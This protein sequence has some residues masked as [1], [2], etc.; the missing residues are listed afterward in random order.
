MRV[1]A[2]AW[3]K[4]GLCIAVLSLLCSISR[5]ADAPSNVAGT[6]TFSVSGKAGNAKQTIVIQQDGTKITGTFKGPRQSGTIEGT[7]DDN[8]ISFHVKARRD[9]D[10]TGTVDGDTM[11]GTL[12]SGNKSGDF[13]ASRR[14]ASSS[15]SA[16]TE[17]T[18]SCNRVTKGKL[19]RVSDSATNGRATRIPPPNTPSGAKAKGM[20]W[21]PGGEFS[22]GSD[23]PQFPDARPWH[24][25]HVNGFYVDRTE[26]SNAQYSAFVR[27]TGYVT[28]AE[29][30]PNA[31]DYP[32]ASPEKLVAGSV[33]FAP[34][35]HAV[36]LNNPYQWWNFVKGANWR[37]PEGPQSGL[38]GRMNH[39][40]VQVAYDDAVAYCSWIGG[41]LPTEAEFEFAA[42]G[43]S[44]R[45]HYVWGDEF[46]P[47]GKFMA[48]TFQGEFPQTNTAEDG[49]IGAA[50]VGS[51]PANGYGL[52]DLAG[53]VWEWTSDW[54][55]PDYYQTLAAAGKVAQN[56]RGPSASFDPGEPGVPK[57]VQRGGSFLCTEQYCSRYMVGA[58]GRGAPDTG[59][60]HVGFRCVSN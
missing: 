41:R 23:E 55:R 58:R 20:V 34:Q 36:L 33:V 48:N 56:P 17:T 57:R 26:V 38:R 54:Y 8:K 11:K 22:M 12:T 28:V 29:Q 18:A 16:Q 31:K 19:L 6:W 53:N 2:S 39:P 5:G 24:Q 35:A 52:F 44:A 10:Y 27:A 49:Y 25:V 40:V 9:L 30:I 42:G 15:K 50:P 51:F 60:N 4:P 3:T 32:G 7:V 37:H 46:R 59:T 45:K 13:T 43:G 1:R 47:N 21:I 14:S